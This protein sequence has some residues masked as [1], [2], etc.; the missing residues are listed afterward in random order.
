[1]GK[2]RITYKRQKHKKAPETS[3]YTELMARAPYVRTE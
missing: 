3:S 2:I 1:M